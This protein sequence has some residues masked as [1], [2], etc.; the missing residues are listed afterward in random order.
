M[1]DDTASDTL[2]TL[3]MIAHE[4]RHPID[5]ISKSAELVN[6]AQLMDFLNGEKLREIMDGII[7]SCNRMGVLTSNI[8]ELAHIESGTARAITERGNIESFFNDLKGFLELHTD[9]YNVKFVFKIKLDNPN[10]VTDF[11]KLERIVLNL[12]SNAVKYSGKTNRVVTISVSDSEEEVTVS[13]KDRGKGIGA[14]EINRIFDKFYRVEDFKMRA[15]EGC[16]LGL[17]IVRGFVALLGGDISVVSAEGKGSE[18]T[19]TLPR[20]LDAG[21]TP[22]KTPEISGMY[23]LHKTSVEEIFSD[24]TI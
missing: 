22:G 8:M 17:A 23:R 18:F 15:T 19:V 13:V 20:V 3:A 12:I 2:Q 9:A 4:F 10:I 14:A 6:K 7:N 16:G 21:K 11:R 24:I 1:V 5:I